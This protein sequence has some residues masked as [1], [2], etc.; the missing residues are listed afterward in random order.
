MVQWVLCVM[1]LSLGPVFAS[2]PRRRLCPQPVRYFSFILIV[3]S[4]I[5]APGMGHAARPTSY[6]D[7]SET[8]STDLEPFPKWRQM[9]DRYDDQKTAMKA[10]C[11]AGNCPEKVRAWEKLVSELRQESPRVQLDRVNSYFNAFRYVLDTSNWGKTDYWETPYEFLQNN[12]DCED[13]AIIKYITLRQ[14]GFSQGDM[15]III[16]QDFNLGGI[17]HA[18][19]EVNLNGKRLILD[20]QARQVVETASIYHYKPVYAINQ[21]AWWSFK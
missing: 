16:V 13:Y 10:R 12:G 20:N 11:D 1:L 14:L 21:E 4:A 19:L 7:M 5:L 6:F 9:L 17:M 18:V 3:C 8:R 2:L 15:R